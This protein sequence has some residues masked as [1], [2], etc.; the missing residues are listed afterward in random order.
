MIRILENGSVLAT[1]FLDIISRSGRPAKA[2]SS[3]SRSRRTTRAT[4]S[5]S[6]STR[7][8]A[9]DSVLVALRAQ[10]H[11]IRI[12]PTPPATFP[13]LTVPPPA[14]QSQGRHDR[15]LARRRLPLR[16][17]RRR[18]PAATELRADPNRCSAR[19]CAS[20]SRGGPTQRLHDSADNPLRRSAT[21]FSTR[22]G[23]SASAIRS[24][25][26]FDRVTGDLWIGDVGQGDREEVDYEPATARA[27]A[28]T[29]GRCTR[30]SICYQPATG[31]P[32]RRPG[33]P[34]PLHV[35]GLRV[36]RTRTAARSPAACSTRGSA[37]A[38]CAAPT[39]SRTSARTG[40]GRCRRTARGPS[41]PALGSTPASSRHRRRSARTAS[42]R[43]TS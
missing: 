30:A 32:L 34:E 21:A 4:A 39:C 40:S 20:T 13:L 27:A 35:P 29:A 22:S 19:C 15:V 18:R 16:R 26:R 6:C 11:R 3:D 28:T 37:P 33:E 25:S 8:R 7:T 43:S 2:G 17:P 1:P 10:L 31:L 14:H 24:A 9:G 42:A 23:R 5:S 38:T 12:A 36:H 41:R